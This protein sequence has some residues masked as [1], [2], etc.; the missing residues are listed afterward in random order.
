MTS[1]DD[2]FLSA[3]LDGELDADQ[4]QRVDSALVASP[5]L[6]ERLRAISVVRDLVVGLHRDAGVDVAPMVMSRIRRRRQSRFQFSAWG[7]GAPRARQAAAVA[8]ILTFAAGILVVVTLTATHRQP[9]ARF[10]APGAGAAID[11]VITDAKPG[12]G[13]AGGN[14]LAPIVA[15]QPSSSSADAGAVSTVALNKPRSAVEHG[16][17][18][19][20]VDGQS[21]ATDLEL[22]RRLLDSPYRRRFFLSKSGGIGNAQQQVASVVE[23]TTRLGFCK[24]TV[25]QG[26]V[27]DPRHPE[28][29]TV[30]A[31]LVNPNELDRLRDQLK[32]ALPDLIEET[33][34]DPAIV[35]QLADIGRVQSLSPAPLADVLIS[36]EDLALRTKAGIAAESSAQPAGVAGQKSPGRPTAE[37]FQSGPL[38]APARTGSAGEPEHGTELVAAD[39]SAHLPDTTAPAGAP[40]A[41]S[42]SGTEV[43][44]SRGDPAALRS[45]GAKSAD[46]VLVFVWI[47]KPRAS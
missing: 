15:L 4:Q 14:E 3:Y 36:R 26:I 24:I 43:A 40:G 13:T 29:A 44:L 23:H 46:S 5:E 28:E 39:Q 17:A 9:R 22:S 45:A 19:G 27:I 37:Q 6:A 12:P 25:S 34:A 2:T 16:A 31:L 41:E 32:V 8:G 11:N 35:T 10:F 20:G 7:P 30:F 33:T 1:D 18:A 38:P 47:C 21:A 42:I